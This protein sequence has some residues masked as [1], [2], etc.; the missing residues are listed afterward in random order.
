LDGLGVGID[1]SKAFE[2]LSQTARQG[3]PRAQLN[4]ARMYAEDLGVH[5]DLSE[6][7][8]WYEAAARRG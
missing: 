5:R 2:L 3:L 6:A 4:L 1:Y 7:V 8:R